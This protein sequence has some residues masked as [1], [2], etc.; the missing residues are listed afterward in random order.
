MIKINWIEIYWSL[1][2]GFV[3][4]LFIDIMNNVN[5]EGEYRY[6]NGFEWLRFFELDTWV[7][8]NG[9]SL[10]VGFIITYSLIY[11]IKLYRE[12]DEE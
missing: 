9:G 3:L 8:T 7:E 12:E 11:T 10:V 2:G 6:E 5:N 4:A 1:I